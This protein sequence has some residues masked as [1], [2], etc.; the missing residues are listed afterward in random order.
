M[1]LLLF[2]ALAGVALIRA[3]LDAGERRST[4][5]SWTP[6]ILVTLLVNS[7]FESFTL[8][9]IGWL[10]LVLCAVRA[11]QSRSWRGRIESDLA[12]SDLPEAF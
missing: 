8:F 5:Y 12:V 4:V 9:G 7:V 1:G 2:G 6:L 11:G 10:L 3:W